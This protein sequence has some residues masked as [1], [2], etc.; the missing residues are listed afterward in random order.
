[1]KYRKKPV[2]IEARRFCGTN[3]EAHAVYKWV[4][5][6]TLGSFEPLSVLEGDVP[7]PESGVSIDPSDGAFLIAT[8][9]GVMKARPG[10][11]IIRGVQGEF[12][13]V[14]DSIFRETYEAVES[15]PDVRGLPLLILDDRE[16]LAYDSAGG[17]SPHHPPRWLRVWR[18]GSGFVAVV[19]E[20][21]VGDDHGRGVMNAA[22]DFCEAVH[23]RFPTAQVFGHFMGDEVGEGGIGDSRHHFFEIRHRRGAARDGRCL[24][25][26]HEDEVVG[27]VGAGVLDE[28]PPALIARRVAR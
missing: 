12:Y 17:W 18:V 1:M 28:F 23:E 24:R 22:E 6:N 27:V 11:W 14:K 10:D 16:W 15:S 9:E 26:V 2:V 5:E 4:E 21:W 8:L 7:A 25:T 19:T 13:P 20:Q 3:A